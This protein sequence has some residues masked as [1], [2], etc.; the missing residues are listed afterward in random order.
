MSL[1]ILIKF[2]SRGRRQKFLSTYN[3]YVRMASDL[4][5]IH[6]LITLDIDDPTMKE[7]GINNGYSTVIYGKSE[8]KVH[9]INRDLNEFEGYDIIL[10]ASD[11]MIPVVKGYDDI[12]RNQMSINFPDMDGVL[13]FN[14]GYA[15]DRLNTLC[16]LGKKYY[17]R[18]KYIYC[19]A[20]KSLWC[21]N[22]FMKV[23]KILK[24]QVY[25]DRVI[26]RHEHYANTPT[27]KMDEQYK[28]TESFYHIDKK[29]FDMRESVNFEIPVNQ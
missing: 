1:K 19:P 17:D 5:N 15:Q 21:D 12:I 24:K 13:H 7:I 16:I 28:K 8:N 10:L 4:S 22:E 9:A 23:S 20:Y 3:Q 2:P 14:D 18:F 26:I 6:F 29:T 11:D 25:I 27:V